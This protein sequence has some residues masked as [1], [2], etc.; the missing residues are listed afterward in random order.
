MVKQDARSLS[1]QAQEA[2]RLRVV[3]AIVGGMKQVDA[4]RAFGVSRAAIGKWMKQ[5]RQGGKRSL[6]ARAQGRPKGPSRLK[7]WQAAQIVRTIIDR[8]PDQ[9]KMPF[10]LWT[11]EAVGELIA[12]RFGVRVSPMTVGRWLRRWGL[13][14]QKPVRRAWEQNPKQVEHWL[15]VQYPSIRSEAKAE[16]AQ[17]HWGDEMGLRS[18]H[19]AGT[20][21][22]RKGQT[23]VVAGTGQRWRCNMIS[24]ITGRGSLRFMVFKRR[25]TAEVFIE[26]MRRL[27]RSVGR[28]VYLIVDGHPVHVS[29]KVQQWLAG[30]TDRIR[31]ILLPAYSPDLNPDEFLNHD[32][33]QNAVGR[34]R[35]TSREDMVADVRGYLRSTQNRPA[36]VRRYFEAPSVQYAME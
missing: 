24:A 17:I 35:A 32:V 27:I 8:T 13:T 23:P 2:L 14:P 20:S 36:I 3:A 25:F 34:R 10:V 5:Y 18:D 28:K 29:R 16:R 31:L 9:L 26:F 19:Q 12:Q 4:V 22:G 1:S 15:K 6:K 7:G 33:K 21:Y 11:R 30:R